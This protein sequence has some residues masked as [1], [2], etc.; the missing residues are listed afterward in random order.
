MYLKHI[1]TGELVEIL[2][3]QDVINPRALMVR[4]RSDINDHLQ[5]TC[6]FVKAEL[7]F[8]SDEPLP[9]CWLGA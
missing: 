8:P 2:D 9:Q 5:R 4:A 7:S 6:D 1:P 3:L